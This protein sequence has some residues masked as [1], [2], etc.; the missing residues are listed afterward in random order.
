[1]LQFIPTLAIVVAAYNILAFVSSATLGSTLFSLTLA[2][3][4][5]MPFTVDTLLLSLAA[6]LLF[7]EILK[8]TRTG[9]SS[10]I[11]HVL[12]M[13]LFIICLLEFILVKHMGTG[14]FF[15]IMLICL[16]DVIAGFTIT[17]TAARRDFTMGPG[18]GM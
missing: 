14:T 4:D 1:M 6:I 3:G 5:S 15:L 16:L 17:I 13:V 11:D 7:V 12:S 18:G 8:A 10:I 9:S 2:S